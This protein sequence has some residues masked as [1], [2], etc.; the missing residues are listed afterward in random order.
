MAYTLNS[1]LVTATFTCYNRRMNSR[2]NSLHWVFATL[3]EAAWAPLAILVFYVIGLALGLF[4]VFPWLDMPSHFLGGAAVTYFYRCAARNAQG[5]VGDIPI[6]VQVL[7]AFTSAGTT[8][9]LWEFYENFL[10]HFLGTHMVHGLEDTIM[11]LLMG[12]SGALF[13]SILYRRG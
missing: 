4:D 10:D 1:P 11:D 9:V 5:L 3:R 6:P 2:E 12:L 13:L 7:L 8:A